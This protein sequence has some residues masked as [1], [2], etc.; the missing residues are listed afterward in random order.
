[1]CVTWPVA[2][3]LQEGFGRKC[4]SYVAPPKGEPPFSGVLNLSAK[5]AFC[6]T[7]DEAEFFEFFECARGSAGS[8]VASFRRS[9]N[10]QTDSAVVEAVIAANDFDQHRSSRTTQRKVSR[11]VQKPAI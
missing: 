5:R 3:P 6:Y 10:R 11:R 9:P 1:G 8:N 7:L 4:V 2:A